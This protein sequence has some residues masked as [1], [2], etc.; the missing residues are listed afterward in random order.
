MKI[1]E[2]TIGSQNPI[3]E[4]LKK[5]RNGEVPIRNGVPKEHAYTP[6][7]ELPVKYKK[8]FEW[9]KIKVHQY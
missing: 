6:I 3:Q 7:G 9:P 5:Y 1:E 2:K 4:R 8:N